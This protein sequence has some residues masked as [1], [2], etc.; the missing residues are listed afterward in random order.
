MFGKL[1]YGVPIAFVLLGVLVADPLYRAFQYRSSYDALALALKLL[2]VA[3]I[4]S[5]YACLVYARSN[6]LNYLWI[7]FIW[8]LYYYFPFAGNLARF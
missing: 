3:V 2:F 1:A 4:L 6:W 5:S 7:A 8:F